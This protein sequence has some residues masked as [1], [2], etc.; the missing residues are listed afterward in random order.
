MKQ[1]M[2]N[3]L[4]LA[5]SLAVVACDANKSSVAPLPG[6][7]GATT[8]TGGDSSGTGGT[9]GDGGDTA[10]AGG[11]MMVECTTPTP[12]PPAGGANYPFPQNR[13]LMCS[14]P[15]R[16]CFQKQNEQI[17]AAFAKWKEA[18]V[19]ASGAGGNLRVQRDTW[20]NNDTV[21]EGIAYG[22]LIGVYMNDKEL[23][24]KLW[25]YAKAHMNNNG[26]MS[27]H[28]DSSGAV[29]QANYGSTA[30]SDADEDM[31]WALLMAGEQWGGTYASE[32]TTLANKIL[33]LEVDSANV[34][35]PGDSDPMGG[36]AKT[37]PSY[38]APSYYRTFARVTG[39]AR[40][41]S[42]AQVSYQVLEACANDSTGLVPDWCSAN[43]TAL[44]NGPNYTWDAA[45]TPWRI[46]LDAC[47]NGTPE[48]ITYLTRLSGFF[49]KLRV[50]Q[51]AN[52]YKLDGTAMS[53]QNG[54]MAFVGPAGVGAM[55]VP[56]GQFQQF[57]DNVQSNLATTS[58]S[59]GG[60]FTYYN[61]SWALLS[62]LVMSGNF[63]DYTAL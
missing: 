25:A 13:M 18:Y 54:A 57:V 22:M 34:L 4:A 31:A 46:A 11:T 59:S 40:W 30:A 20:D 61:T 49:G 38:L 29:I 35:K 17:Q 42:V 47:M 45:R 21:S 51:I 32:G 2:L 52:G 27:W 56:N 63:I 1:V 24:D 5:L 60:T 33:Q 16:T 26:F 10:G 6:S 53:T 58:I 62:M 19:T 28:I 50:G 12:S 48:A 9:A 8:G 44:S 23:F 41:N 37:N 14:H 39:N 7:G 3:R 55:G 15:T 43:G 36:T